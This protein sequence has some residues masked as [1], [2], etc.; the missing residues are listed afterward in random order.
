M[1]THVINVH[2][3]ISAEDRTSRADIIRDLR[4]QL[5]NIQEQPPYR[6]IHGASWWTNSVSSVAALNYENVGE[7]REAEQEMAAERELA[8]DA[9]DCCPVSR[10]S[11]CGDTITLDGGSWRSDGKSAVCTV[12]PYGPHEPVACRRCGDTL[13]RD[14]SVIGEWLSDREGN[15]RG[16]CRFGAWATGTPHRA[17]GEY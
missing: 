2:L 9:A 1:Q 7:Q 11:R 17:E 4:K 12:G 14:P 6:S 10:C 16:V 13:V 3:R 8:E 5:S 15:Q